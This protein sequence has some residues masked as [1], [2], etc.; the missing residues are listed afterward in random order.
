VTPPS[1]AA[2]LNSPTTTIHDDVNLLSAIFEQ[3]QANFAT[4]GNPVGTNAEITAAL[5]GANDLKLD[6]IPRDH[7]AINA[8]EELCD[9]WGTPFRFH[10]ISGTEMQVISAG[11]DRRFATED[12]AVAP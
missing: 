9:R 1:L 6:L 12:D 8:A 4:Q 11:P 5:T 7:P 10:Q 2:A 3:W